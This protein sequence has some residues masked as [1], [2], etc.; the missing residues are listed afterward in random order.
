MPKKRLVAEGKLL[1]LLVIALGACK[2]SPTMASIN[3]GE[4]TTF[5]AC[6][7]TSG[8]PGISV[9]VA[10]FVTKNSD[11]IRVFGLEMSFDPQ[12]FQYQE[13]ISGNLTDSWAAIDANK[14]N[15]GTL[16]IGGFAG[17]GRTISR[18]SQGALALVRLKVTAANSSNS[19]PT[20]ICINQFTDDLSGFKPAPAC[21]TFTFKK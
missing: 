20:E 13:V 19:Q 10:V 12:M 2:K 21:T 4:N 11:E 17:G 3:L 16:R 9:G 8:G 1:L 6:D 7:P 5:V 15:S 14:V 18:D